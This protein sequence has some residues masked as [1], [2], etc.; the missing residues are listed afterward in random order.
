MSFSPDGSALALTR[1]VAN[2]IALWD[3]Q[4][5]SVRSLLIRTPSEDPAPLTLVAYSADGSR[6][7]TGNVLE[8]RVWELR[9]P[10]A[11]PVVIPHPPQQRV[12]SAI[13]LS[14]DKHRLA[15]G[16]EDVRVWDLR[17]PAG[18]PLLLRGFPSQA[19]SGLAFSPDGELLAGGNYNETTQ[20]WDLRNPTTP[21]V[22]LPGP[23]A[24]IA[25]APDG[26]HLVVGG[27]DGS[28]R[29]WSLG[30]AAA[31]YL[32]TRVWRNLS[33]GEWRLYV[34]DGIPYERTCPGLPPGVGAPGARP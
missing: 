32:C 5:L 30:A 11:P 4:N 31:E 2:T 28:V 34:G 18:P 16:T 25:F 13:A 22:S 21:P 7:V 8:A 27:N 6:L 19:F 9:K 3:L 12:V 15:V 26:Q 24:S 29:L 1:P 33:M 20:L 10:D 14:R 17:N 23:V